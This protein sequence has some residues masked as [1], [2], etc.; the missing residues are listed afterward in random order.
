M[1]KTYKKK[2]KCRKP[3]T[4]PSFLG[5]EEIHILTFERIKQSI[6]SAPVLS[7]PNFDGPFIL[8][9]DPCRLGLGAVLYQKKMVSYKSVLMVAV[10]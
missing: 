10:V 8:H 5:I 6:T 9:M 3:L 4:E 1:F 2:C 7:Y